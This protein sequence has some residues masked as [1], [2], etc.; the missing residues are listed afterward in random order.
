MLFDHFSKNIHS[1]RQKYIQA[2][3]LISTPLMPV[4]IVFGSFEVFLGCSR[5]H[6]VL[7][8]LSCNDESDLTKMCGIANCDLMMSVTSA[9]MLYTGTY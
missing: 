2:Q 1:N 9:D 7:N 4:K 3:E 8:R 5:L 6:N